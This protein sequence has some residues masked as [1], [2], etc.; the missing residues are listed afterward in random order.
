MILQFNREGRGI[1][2][3]FYG[4]TAQL[5]SDGVSDFFGVTA[6]GGVQNDCFHV[7]PTM[8]LLAFAIKIV[9]SPRA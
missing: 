8:A 5:R 4:F 1:M 6:L 9:A 3:Y 2:G 7:G